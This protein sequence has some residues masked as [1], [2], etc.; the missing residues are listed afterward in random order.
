MNRH[1]LDLFCHRH[2][3][4]SAATAAALELSGQRPA[5]ADW[6]AF[7]VVLLR[8][9]GIAG[10]GAGLL[11]FVAA[12]W[13]D[14]GLLGRFVLL[15]TV[16][17]VCVGGALWRPAPAPLGQGA[18]LLATLSTGGLLALFGQSYQTG[19][20]VHELFFT[21]AALALPFALA[22]LSGALWAVWWTVLNVGLALLCG[23]L[24][25]G[26][27]VWQWLHGTGLDRSVLLMLPCGL[28]LLGA[29]GFA[30]L[31]HGRFR[32]ASPGW[33][34]QFLTGIGLVYGT[35]ATLAAVSRFWSH[36]GFDGQAAQRLMVA[37]VFALVSAGLGYATWRRQRDVF[38]LALL[39]ASWIVISTGWLIQAMEF[40]GLGSFFGITLWLIAAST[41]SGMQL[42]RWQRAWR[43]TGA[44]GRT[45]GAA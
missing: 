37:L 35:A 5:E 36:D 2:R 17:L 41:A 27:V 39:A 13:Q 32:L 40:D 14:Y 29:A 9:A 44:A 30:R 42:M 10:V 15:Q 23:A 1:Q 6:R 21:W 38:P 24:G 25:Q 3:L 34:A 18:L 28:N 20:D 45:G 16:L 12:N 31:Q 7:A 43:G 19:A 22:G 4:D 26:H 8:G 33:L 11:F